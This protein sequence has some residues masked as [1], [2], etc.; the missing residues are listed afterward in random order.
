MYSAP[1]FGNAHATEL[2]KLS[3]IL[4]LLLLLL[5]LYHGLALSPVL[6]IE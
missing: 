3:Y 4:L 2:Y 1:G 5:R 6:S